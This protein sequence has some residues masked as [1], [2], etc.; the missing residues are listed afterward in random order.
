M[1]QPPAQ[2]ID[3]RHELHCAHVWMEEQPE[4]PENASHDQ[5]VAAN[6]RRRSCGHATPPEKETEMSSSRFVLRREAP[7]ISFRPLCQHHQAAIVRPVG[8]YHIG[9]FDTWNPLDSTGGGIEDGGRREPGICQRHPHRDA[10]VSADRVATN[11]V[12]E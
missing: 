12:S 1:D 2:T 4:Y 9:L 8:R 5:R 10:T 3:G 11:G 6:P 7:E